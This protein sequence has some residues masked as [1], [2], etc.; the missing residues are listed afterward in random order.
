M[1]FNV[2]LKCECE[3]A[4]VGRACGS[5]EKGEKRKCNII[6]IGKTWNQREVMLVRGF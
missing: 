2:E 5:H 3:G 1:A 4:N 6:F